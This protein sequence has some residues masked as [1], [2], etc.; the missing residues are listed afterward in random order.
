MS[1]YFLFSQNRQIQT[2]RAWASAGESKRG[3]LP[4]CQWKN[5]ANYFRTICQIFRKWFCFLRLSYNRLPSIKSSTFNGLSR[6][7][8]IVLAGNLISNLELESFKQMPKLSTLALTSNRIG[9]IA[10][11]AFVQV[12]FLTIWD[13]KLTR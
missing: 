2:P 3:P 6:L 13:D 12:H 10:S 5:V 9:S 8:T 1:Y 4:K 7:Q 11:R